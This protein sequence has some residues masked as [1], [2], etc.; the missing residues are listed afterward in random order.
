[1]E[2]R[3]QY[4]INTVK[5]KREKKNL[6]FEKSIVEGRSFQSSLLFFDAGCGKGKWRVPTP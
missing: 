2:L 6:K 4:K 1:M 3:P 5:I